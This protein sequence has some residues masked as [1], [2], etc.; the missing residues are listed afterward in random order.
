M[1]GS[2]KKQAEVDSNEFLLLSFTHLLSNFL[3]KID[4]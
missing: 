3:K 4:F 1:F 2:V